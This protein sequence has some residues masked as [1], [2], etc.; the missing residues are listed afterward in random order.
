MRWGCH[1]ACLVQ[2]GGSEVLGTFDMVV[3]R[4]GVDVQQVA[5]GGEVT[6]QCLDTSSNDV[7]CFAGP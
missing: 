5:G 3:G 7:V 1:G 4:P 6:C 2:Q